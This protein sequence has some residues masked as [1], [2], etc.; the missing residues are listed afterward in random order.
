MLLV[1][2]ACRAHWNAFPFQLQISAGLETVRMY[3]KLLH[4]HIGSQPWPVHIASTPLPTVGV[5]KFTWRQDHKKEKK[6]PRGSSHA[7]KLCSHQWTEVQERACR[8]FTIGC[9]VWYGNAA[10]PGGP[11]YACL[12]VHLS[13]S[14]SGRV[15]NFTASIADARLLYTK[16]S[17]SPT[18]PGWGRSKRPNDVIW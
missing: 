15:L 13:F 10:E 6:F 8:P 4:W 16:L 18:K 11:L 17:G 9:F 5:Y 1:P 12:T 7:V 3:A 14:P 2:Y